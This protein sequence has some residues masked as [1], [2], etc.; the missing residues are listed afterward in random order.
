M[1]DVEQ[2]MTVAGVGLAASVATFAYVAV[3]MNDG[4]PRIEGQ[5][6][7]ALFARP[8]H[9]LDLRIGASTPESAPLRR[10]VAKSMAG[11]AVDYSPTASIRRNP[12]MQA[13]VLQWTGQRV[14]VLGPEGPLDIGRGEIARDMGRLVDV[15]LVEG[16]WIAVFERQ[17]GSQS[18]R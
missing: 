5:E 11:P 18:S 17:A 10:D 4:I 16:R 13:R 12:E 2:V 7:L 1:P 14:T 8:S 6:H 15:R 3:S 9:A